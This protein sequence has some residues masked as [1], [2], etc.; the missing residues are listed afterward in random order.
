MFSDW[1]TGMTG[2]LTV[3]F[4][5]AA[6]FVGTPAYRVLFA[7]LAVVA[8]VFA[9]YRVCDKEYQRAE[10]AEQTLRALLA[11]PKFTGHFYQFQ[12]FPRTGLADPSFIHEIMNVAKKRPPLDPADPPKCDYDVFLEVYLQNDV[13]GK[14]SIL[15]YVFEMEFEG[16]YVK[17]EREFSFKGW[18]LEREESQMNA[19]DGLSIVH[20]SVQKPI[21]DLSAIAGLLEQGKGVEGWLHYVLKN[22]AYTEFDGAKK[23]DMRLTINDGKGEPHLINKAWT[24]EPRPWKVAHDFSSG[25][26][27]W[28]DPLSSTR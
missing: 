20:D 5:V 10:A 18:I 9:C 13:P 8:G 7:L 17:L 24:G 1:L 28:P 23:R 16:S 19:R 12:I 21:P 6:L 3:P 15:E 4:T 25:S 2:P 11:G 22:V 26:H 14:G 27:P